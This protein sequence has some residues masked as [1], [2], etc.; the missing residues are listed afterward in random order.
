MTTARAH[1]V[2][3]LFCAVLLV[4]CA[5][6]R[7][8]GIDAWKRDLEAEKLTPIYPPRAGDGLGT[9]ATFDA[10]GR[11]IIVTSGC[12]AK[13][14]SDS[15]RVAMLLTEQKIQSSASLAGGA[16]DLVK[17]KLD[18]S[19][20]FSVSSDVNV[21]LSPISPHISRYETAV[22]KDAVGKLDRNSVCYKAAVNPRN[23]ILFYVLSVDGLNFTFTDKSDN[24]LKLNASLLAAAKVDSELARKFEG[25][26]T[27]SIAEKMLIGYRA[28]TARELPGAFMDVIELEEL[29][30]DQLQAKRL[31]P[32]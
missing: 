28:M 3:A 15:Y 21:Q 5:T 12:F 31:A 29:S 11:E 19:F 24:V 4:S 10:A 17:G 7:E 16:S 26:A 27:L 13:V 6:P 18:I 30:P 20:A 32:R 2:V 23:V 14:N 8:L 22:L 1:I 9:I 25:K